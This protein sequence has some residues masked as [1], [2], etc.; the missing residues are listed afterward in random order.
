MNTY[1]ANTAAGYAALGQMIAWWML[2]LLLASPVLSAI[3]AHSKGRNTTG[4]L[5]CGLVF[6][7]LGLLAACGMSDNRRGE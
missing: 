6:G 3:V 4:W 5:I 7:P 2:A 1:D